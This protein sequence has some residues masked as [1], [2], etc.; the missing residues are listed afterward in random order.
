MTLAL[1]PPKQVAL[2]S[3]S[4]TTLPPSIDLHMWQ[5]IID[6]VGKITNA[7]CKLMFH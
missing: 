7:Q 6:F 5:K 3:N 2:H 4:N 1:N